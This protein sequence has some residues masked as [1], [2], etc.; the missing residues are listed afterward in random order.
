[1]I[2]R[3]HL[4]IIQAVDRQGSMTA[5]ASTLCLTQPALSHA[6]KKLEQLYQEAVHK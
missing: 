4:A 1:M 2:E 3:I 6:M 5:A